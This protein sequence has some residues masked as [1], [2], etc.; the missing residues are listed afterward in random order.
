MLIIKSGHSIQLRLS[1]VVILFFA[2]HF[3]TLHNWVYVMQ[4]VIY[5][6]SV[7]LKNISILINGNDKQNQRFCISK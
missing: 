2:V 7:S 3:V 4:A 5:F 6:S 1:F